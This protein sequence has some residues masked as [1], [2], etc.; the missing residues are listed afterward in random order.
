MFVIVC[1]KLVE[2]Q[3]ICEMANFFYEFIIQAIVSALLS[4]VRI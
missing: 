2:I 4:G 1:L 3:N